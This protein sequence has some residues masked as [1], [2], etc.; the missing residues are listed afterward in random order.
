MTDSRNRVARW[1]TIGAA[2]LSVAACSGSKD[3][4]TQSTGSGGNNT[5]G[6]PV[7]SFSL[8]TVN[9][10]SLPYTMYS[11]TAG[12]SVDVS[13]GT[14]SILSTG[15]YVATI[16][17]RET[18]LGHVSTYVD[19]TNGTWLLSTPALIVF[20]NPADGTT[21]NATWDGSKLTMTDAGTA[22]TFVYAKLP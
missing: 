16:T 17:Q 4:P 9:A 18:I 14:F 11:D 2:A 10:K 15:K 3:A 6:S 7:G 21:Q 8:S 19:S 1:I 13:A 22:A 12:Y 5:P 20:T